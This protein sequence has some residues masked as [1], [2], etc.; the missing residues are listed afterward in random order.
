MPK[1]RAVQTNTEGLRTM[2][3]HSRPADAP[4][5]NVPRLFERAD[6]DVPKAFAAARKLKYPRMMGIPYISDR[7]KSVMYAWLGQSQGSKDVPI[8]DRQNAFR[9]DM[10]KDGVVMQAFMRYLEQAGLN[11]VDSYVLSNV[12]K[13]NSIA[14][15]NAGERPASVSISLLIIRS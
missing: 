9:Y 14:T 6:L 12:L 10:G 11:E 2:D 1:G 3:S 7:S 13:D 5:L 4:F 15:A 8:F